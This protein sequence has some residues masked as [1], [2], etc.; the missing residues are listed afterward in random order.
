MNA[1]SR[2]AAERLGFTFEGVF[3]S[4]MIVKGRNRDTAWFSMLADE[5]PVRRA[6]MDRWLETEPGTVCSASHARVPSRLTA[7]A[8]P[9]R[10]AVIV[11]S[12]VNVEKSYGSWPVLQGADLEVPD[13]AR[14]G[15]V[16]PNGAG[17]ST[18]LR[19]LQGVEAPRV[20]RWCGARIW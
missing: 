10:G 5:W 14:I 7:R 16:G 2:A 8:L 9:Y 6:A 12:L 17:K 18:L 3:R 4:H 19:I 15:V 11:V 13:G 1:R 20:A